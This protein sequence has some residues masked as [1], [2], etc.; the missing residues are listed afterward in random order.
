[1]VVQEADRYCGTPPVGSSATARAFGAN[2][3]V[4]ADGRS[5]FLV[6][7][8]V[9]PPDVAIRSVGG[10]VVTRLPDRRRVLAVAAFDAYTALSRHPDVALAGPV[11][12]DAE[13]FGRFA[14]LVGLDGD[15]P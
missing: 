14:Q 13:R 11:S 15:S 5:L 1:M 12:I 9:G 8:W 3:E 10:Q 7:G 2:V 6:V 4:A